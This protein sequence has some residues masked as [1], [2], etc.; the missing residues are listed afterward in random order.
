MIAS[1]AMVDEIPVDSTHSALEFFEPAKLLVNYSRAYNEEIFTQTSPDGP[2]LEFEFSGAKSQVTGTVID[3]RSI[4]LQLAI[5]L[6]E[7]N[8]T[9]DA[10]TGAVPE[11]EGCYVNNILHSVFSNC[12]VFLQGN[13]VST[14][15]NLY[16]HKVL[17]ETEVSHPT[18]CKK[19]LLFCQGYEYETDP[20]DIEDGSAFEKRRDRLTE[21][22]TIYVYGKVNADFFGTDK[23]I[24]PGVEV[25]LRLTRAP[26]TLVTISDSTDREYGLVIKKAS[27]F[28]HKLELQHETF[29]SLEKALLKKPAR[30][31]FTEVICKSFVV[32]T[33][34]TQFRKDDV[35]NRE[36]V[37][38][39]MFAMG[40]ETDFTGRSTTNPF[41]YQKFGV[42]KIVVAREGAPVGGTPLNVS[43]SDIRAY[44]NTL[45]ALGV[46]H[47]G[48]G[49]PYDDFEH[50][51][52][53]VF[54]LTADVQTNDD[55]LR[56]E[57]TGGRL[58]V[59]LD[60]KEPL[61]KPIRVFFYGERK[62]NVYIS[63]AR[64]VLKNSKFY[65]G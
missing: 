56:P 14:A 61:D 48:N 22:G 11:P 15:N 58:S 7:F 54:R 38:R 50:H 6:I 23:Y 5:Q 32:S 63:S 9:P 17:M 41:H 60:F 35:F 19:G 49:I 1:Q 26:N 24:L 21:D 25:R 2:T 65:Y 51:Y 8:P 20:S 47:A 12:E 33:G 46:E 39:L 55:S 3:P 36:P 10:T 34:T 64:E 29:M 30:Y 62:S 31:P 59:T 42:Q 18:E 40:T 13:Q 16:H 27:L 45:Q 43:N 28:V 53:H 4:E 37:S 57:L 44:H 52:I